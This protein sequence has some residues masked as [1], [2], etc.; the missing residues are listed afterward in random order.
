[1]VQATVPSADPSRDE[2]P[3][4]ILWVPGMLLVHDITTR[5]QGLLCVR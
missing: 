3:W 4:P 1:M 2:L 5:D